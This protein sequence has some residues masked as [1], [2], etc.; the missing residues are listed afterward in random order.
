[1]DFVI[2]VFCVLHLSHSRPYKRV[3]SLTGGHLSTWQSVICSQ[4]AQAMTETRLVPAPVQR[5]RLNGQMQFEE[6]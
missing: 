3:L 4:D 2:T 5:P 1:M 6:I